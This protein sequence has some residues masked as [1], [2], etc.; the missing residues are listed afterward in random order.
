VEAF[1]QDSLDGTVRLRDAAREAGVHPVY[2]ARVFRAR[3][4]CSIGDYI[5]RMRVLRASAC[6]LQ[7]NR[8][9][10][11]AAY[12]AAFAD[13]AHFARAFMGEIGLRPRI[14]LR[15]RNALHRDTSE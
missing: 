4:G 9:L 7:T 2:L 12:E 8:N 13:Q 3:H 10:C 14:L 1:L 5:R 11:E 6:T 15:L